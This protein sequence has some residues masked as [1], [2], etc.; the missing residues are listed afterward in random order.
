MRLDD[1]PVHGLL[2]TDRLVLEPLRDEHAD[3][4]APLL[5]DPALHEFIGGAPLPVAALRERYA[6]LGRGGTPDGSQ[7]WLNWVLRLRET[8]RPVGTV[9]AT[10]TEQDGVLTAEVAWVVAVSFQGRGLATEAARAM[11][12]ELRAA[13]A[14]VVIAHVHPDH[15]ASGAVARAVGL[16]ATDVRVD[17]ETRW[18]G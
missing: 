14:D 5:D 10:V 2:S 15:T 7:R 9:Q 1:W 12:A 18:E 13:G 17:G 3:E 4:L 16:A 8:G 6:R 11:V